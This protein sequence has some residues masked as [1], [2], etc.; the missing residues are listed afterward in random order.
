MRSSMASKIEFAK[1]RLLDCLRDK[2]R[3]VEHSTSQLFRGNEV[4]ARTAE[5]RKKFEQQA[6]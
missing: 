6:G 2:T 5:A 4:T 1:P 3:E